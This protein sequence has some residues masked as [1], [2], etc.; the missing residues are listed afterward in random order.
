MNDN[1]LVFVFE[2]E[3]DRERVM[4][5]EPWAYDKYLVILQRIEED[6]AIEEVASQRL[7][8]GATS[9]HTSSQDES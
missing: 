8:L 3:A 1:K 7:L 4:L 5:G 6:E 2:D 9:R